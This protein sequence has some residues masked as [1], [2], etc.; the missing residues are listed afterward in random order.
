M[1]TLS[2]IIETRGVVRDL[3][4]RG[5]TVGFV[6]TMGALHAGHRSLIDAARDRSDAVVV[7]IFVNP[8]QF[9]QGEDLD[10][11]PRPIETDLELCRHAG[12][13]LVF[14][15]TV[16]TMCPQGATTEVRVAG[17]TAGLCGS[18]RPGH[19][20]GVATVVA[21]LF[22]IV[23]ANTAFFGEKD[24]QQLKTIERMVR[25]LDMPIE[26][27]PCPTVRESDGLA[28]SSRNAY[29]SPAHREQ[30]A[31]ISRAMRSAGESH[32]SG[33]LNAG[34]LIAQM[35]S[36]ILDAGPADVDYISIVG[37]ETLEDIETVDQPARICI[38]ARIG[39]CRLI[40]N[41]PLGA[42]RAMR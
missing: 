41:M 26:I 36:E 5:R 31:S 10:R 24:Y 15:P 37:A 39:G 32:E 42:P 1:K 23:P 27:S 9:T 22:N 35:E 40:D 7:S 28:V 19:F 38:A 3:Q 2:A 25:D 4:S 17:L 13:D 34:R 12:V 8:T 21:K 11:Y 6:P 14:L 18:H 29:L 20:E 33:E 30:A 16:E